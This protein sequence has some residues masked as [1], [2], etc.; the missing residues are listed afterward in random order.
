VPG[1]D[2][3]VTDSGLTDRVFC[4]F[5]VGLHTRRHRLL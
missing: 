1:D 2:G 3:S 4:H 5:H